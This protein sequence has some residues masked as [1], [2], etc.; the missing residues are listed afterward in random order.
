MLKFLRKKMLNPVI[1]DQKMILDKL[2]VLYEQVNE[3]K[4]KEA[5][6]LTFENTYTEN[7]FERP[8]SCTS[9]ICNQEFFGLP[10]YQYWTARLK[11][12]PSFRRK[13]WEYIYIIQVLFENG[14]IKAGKRGLGFGVGTEPLPALFASMGCKITATDMYMDANTKKMW[15]N[16]GQHSGNSIN[17][18]NQRG[19]C[20]DDVFNENVSFRNVDMSS[21]PDDICTDSNT[22]G[23]GGI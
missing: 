18:L 15:G 2:D 13:Q 12:K 14:F 9:Q 17:L 10:F 5:D 1:R 4:I 20:P 19:I 21:I 3:Q 22:G 23:G 16:T 8:L 7:N 6:D 11:E